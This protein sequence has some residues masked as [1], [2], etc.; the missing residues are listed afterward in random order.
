MSTLR[1]TPSSPSYHRS[2]V[3]LPPKSVCVCVC[4]CVISYRHDTKRISL[5]L[6]PQ[7]GSKRNIPSRN[8]KTPLPQD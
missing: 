3:T 7:A 1:R 5:L 2:P 6:C 4:V 8:I